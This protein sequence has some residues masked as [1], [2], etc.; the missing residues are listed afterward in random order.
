[1]KPVFAVYSTFLQR[2]YDQVVHDICRAN[3]NVT[4]AIDR[5]GFVGPD[6][7]THQGVYDIAY[8]R[9]IPNMVVM[10]PKDENELRH[11]MKTALDYEDGPIAYRYPRINGLGVPLD[12]QL[13]AIPIGTWET[14]R[15]GQD[16]AILAVGPMIPI[17]LEAAETLAK[18][19][20]QV[21]VVN[22]RF[23]KPMDEAMLNQLA[24]ED[25]P[26][27]TLEEGAVM[28]GFGSGVLEYYS[29]HNH[30]GMRVK[31]IGV[32]DYFVEHG[33][34]GQQREEVGLTAE[35]LVSELT[36]LVPR[37]RQRA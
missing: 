19:G 28:G 3:L 2:A 30:Y 37:K 31:T 9:S 6:G 13:T 36:A 4:F 27:L 35:R 23:I 15:H 1:M 22:A 16:A 34:V 26:V 7:E 8:L 10:M 17:A 33:S 29:L 12:E 25:I 18:E 20:V 32:P 21:R 24:K 5:A 11:M 14:L